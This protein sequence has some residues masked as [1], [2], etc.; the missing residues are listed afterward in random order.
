MA[1]PILKYTY[2]DYKLWKG[3]WEL[4]E[5]FP[6]AMAPSP[7]INHQYL[8]TMF[9]IQIGNSINDNKC[10]ECIVIVEEDYIVNETTVLR[11]DVAMICNEENNFITKAPEIIVEVIS[12]STARIDENEKFKI[13]EKEGVKFYILAYPDFKMAKVYENKDGFKKIGDFSNEKITINAKC[14]IEINF[15]DIFKKLRG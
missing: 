2:E 12:T 8:S 9:A 6:I 7:I 13:Y 4:I 1:A 3:D 15:N 14:K 10:E 5:G 11:P